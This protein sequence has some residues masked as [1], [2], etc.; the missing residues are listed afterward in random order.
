[1]EASSAI[2]LQCNSE[3]WPARKFKSQ[4]IRKGLALIRDCLLEKWEN[5][6]LYRKNRLS[7]YIRSYEVI[8]Q[9]IISVNMLNNALK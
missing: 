6:R 5:A 4:V 7:H 2:V 3:K 1:M 9:R 8:F